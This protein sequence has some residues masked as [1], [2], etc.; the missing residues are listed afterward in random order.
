MNITYQSG[1]YTF[2]GYE[3]IE[4]PSGYV[5]ADLEGSV[6]ST[7]N[8]LSGTTIPGSGSAYPFTLVR[9]E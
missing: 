9:K 7:G 8:T 2:R 5:F 6:D 1:K 4:Q 3:W